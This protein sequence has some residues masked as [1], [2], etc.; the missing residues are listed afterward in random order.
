MLTKASVN[1]ARTGVRGLLGRR[2]WPGR[3]L[4]ASLSQVRLD[5]LGRLRFR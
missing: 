2:C 1:R 5:R 3:A 4:R